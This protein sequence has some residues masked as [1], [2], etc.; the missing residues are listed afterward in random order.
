MALSRKIVNFVRFD[1][2]HYTDKT[3]RVRQIPIMQCQVITFVMRIMV[4]MIN[5]IRIEQRSP[6]AYAMNLIVLLQ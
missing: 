2:L 6:A 4:Q 1:L 5:T 3:G